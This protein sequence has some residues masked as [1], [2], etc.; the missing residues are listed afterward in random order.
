MRRDRG[1]S[2]ADRTSMPIGQFRILVLSL[3]SFGVL[4]LKRFLPFIF[5]SEVWGGLFRIVFRLVDISRIHFPLLDLVHI[6]ISFIFRSEVIFYFRFFALFFVNGCFV[7]FAFRSFRWPFLF[8]LLL[9]FLGHCWGCLTISEVDVDDGLVGA[10]L[11]FVFGALVLSYCDRLLLKGF[12]SQHYFFS[13]E[14]SYP[15]LFFD[16]FFLQ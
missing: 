13:L 16:S 15:L 2:Y 6:S 7:F 10:S 1:W 12:G 3:K 11:V 14:F 8:F 4:L 9:W 5:F